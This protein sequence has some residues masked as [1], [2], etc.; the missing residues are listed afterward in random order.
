MVSGRESIRIFAPKPPYKYERCFCGECGTSLGEILSS[1]DGFPIPANLLDDE[2]NL[3][4]QF[5]EFVSEKPSW[6]VIGD[7]AKQFETHPEF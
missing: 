7:T 1:Q 3:K 5:H 6:C 2:L 4:I